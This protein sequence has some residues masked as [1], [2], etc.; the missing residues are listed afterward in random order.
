MLDVSHLT[1]EDAA[2]YLRSQVT[3]GEVG[4]MYEGLE[5]GTVAAKIFNRIGINK[6]Y[7]NYHHIALLLPF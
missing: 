5:L 1:T 4:V 6:N 7:R 2:Q 3:A